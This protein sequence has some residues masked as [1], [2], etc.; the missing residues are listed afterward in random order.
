MVACH[1]PW[2]STPN[3]V[4]E[5]PIR[6]QSISLHPRIVLH[7]VRIVLVFTVAGASS[8][9]LFHSHCTLFVGFDIIVL[10][11]YNLVLGHFGHL[12]FTV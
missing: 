3:S 2:L 7:P 12:V 5:S 9:V 10:F 8:L 6:N 11:I 1:E 4:M